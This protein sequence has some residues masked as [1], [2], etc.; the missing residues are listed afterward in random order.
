MTHSNIESF[1]I[2]GRH[3]IRN[4]SSLVKIF[5]QPFLLPSTDSWKFLQCHPLF[6]LYKLWFVI[7]LDIFQFFVCSNLFMTNTRNRLKEIY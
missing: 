5:F 7:N 4:P 1:D 6:S 2:G 3:S